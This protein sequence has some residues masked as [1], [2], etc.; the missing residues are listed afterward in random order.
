[1]KKRDNAPA[2]SFHEVTGGD[3][4]QIGEVWLLIDENHF[5]GHPELQAWT[6]TAADGNYY[7]PGEVAAFAFAEDLVEDHQDPSEPPVMREFETKPVTIRAVRF[8]A[9]NPCSGARRTF[10]EDQ[11]DGRNIRNHCTCGETA[12]HVHTMHKGQ[13]CVLEDGD[14]IVPEPDGQHFYPVKPDVFARKYQF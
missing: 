14:W 6:I 4:I 1:M 9:A 2:R 5:F 11:R 7:Y 8:F 10:P 13:T 3:Y 12:W